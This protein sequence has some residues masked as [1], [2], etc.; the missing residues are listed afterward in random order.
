MRKVSYV[1]EILAE[2]KATERE[3]SL[4]ASIKNDGVFGEVAQLQRKCMK[5]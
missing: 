1:S 3:R 5:A 2:L 4:E